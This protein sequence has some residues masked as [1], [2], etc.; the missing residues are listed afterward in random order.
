MAS[1]RKRG[2]SWQAQVR[3]RKT[4]SIGKSF[5]RKADAERWA[6]EQEALMQTGQFEQIQ[7]TDLNLADLMHSYMEKVTPTKRGAGQ[8]FRRISRLLKERDLMLTPLSLA[9]PQIFFF[10][11]PSE[12]DASGPAFEPA[13][14]IW[15]CYVTLGIW[16]ALNGAGLLETIRCL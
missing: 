8:E 7:T 12:T 9:K 6:I 3:S 11:L 2:K 13:N 5:H 1:I 15:F 10:L 14:M 4:G 16:P